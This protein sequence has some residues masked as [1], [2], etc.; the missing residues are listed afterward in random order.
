M[1]QN[2]LVK[3]SLKMNNFIAEVKVFEQNLFRLLMKMDQYNL[4]LMM[5]H[6]MQK[7]IQIQK[8]KKLEK[9]NKLLLHSNQ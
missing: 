1:D 4:N 2:N 7:L 3:F 8:T 9:I 6:V 5:T